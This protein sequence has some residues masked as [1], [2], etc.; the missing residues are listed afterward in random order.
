[1]ADQECKHEKT[2]EITTITT[3]KKVFCVYCNKEVS[4]QRR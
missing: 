2:R 3:G 4:G 1:M